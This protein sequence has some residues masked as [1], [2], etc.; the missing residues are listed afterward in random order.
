VINSIGVGRASAST[1]TRRERG[2]R[3]SPIPAPSGSRPRSSTSTRRPGSIGAGPAD[4]AI[5][6]IDARD[7]DSYYS[8][9]TGKA[10][11]A[12]RF[13]Y[14]PGGSRATAPVAPRRG[15]FDHLEPP[16]WE[17]SAAMV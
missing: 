17:F 14:P 2:S 5:D 15:H 1:S 6:V 12:A 7:K 13:P 3:S 9:V 4:A 16:A 11:Q 8:D 10:P